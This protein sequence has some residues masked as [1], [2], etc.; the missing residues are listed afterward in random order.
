MGNHFLR[1]SERDYLFYLCLKNGLA[2]TRKCTFS[3]EEP[4][5]IKKNLN[6]DRINLHRNVCDE[7][8]ARNHFLSERV[9][10]FIRI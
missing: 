8:T 9:F 10:R 5:F 7:A 1:F 2:A 4:Y 6:V 3:F